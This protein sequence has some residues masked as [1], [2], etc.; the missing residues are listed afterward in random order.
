MKYIQDKIEAFRIAL[1]AIKA[2]RSRSI[3]TT[4]GIIIGITAVTIT[5]TASNGLKNQFK[6]NAAAMGKDVFYVA[7]LPWII[8]GNFSQFRNREELTYEDGQELIKNLDQAKNVIPTT[9]TMQNIKYRSN[10]MEDVPIAGTTER[11]VDIVD[12]FPEYGRF[13][14]PQDVQYRKYVCVIGY[15]IKEKMFDQID[16]INKDIK[17]GRYKFRIIGVMEKRGSAGFFGGPNFDRQIFVPV[18]TIMK[19]YGSRNRGFS[20]IVQANEDENMTDFRYAVIGE[21]RKIRKLRPDEQDDFTLNSMD[22][23]M[24]A[25]NSVMGVIVLIGLVITS[26]SLFVGAVGVMNIMFVTVTER[27]REIGIRKALGATSKTIMSQFLFES[28]SICLI[29]GIIGLI[30]SFGIAKIIDSLLLPATVSL[31]IAL[32]SVLISILVGV[33]SGIIPAYNASKLNP[34]EALHYE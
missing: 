4:L 14:S 24:A 30:L 32:L 25:Y 6:E 8:M 21:M 33:V 34:V 2:N 28:S 15:E 16:P 10:I 11:Q 20:I 13:I 22:T 12:A 27:T 31:P 5:M 3:L 1:F 18:T 26:I 23:L 19:A 7:R 29:G 17:I 9:N